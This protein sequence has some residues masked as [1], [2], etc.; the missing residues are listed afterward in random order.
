MLEPCC[1]NHV[2]TWPD[3]VRTPRSTFSVP[4]NRPLIHL[5]ASRQGQDDPI[6]QPTELAAII[7]ISIISKL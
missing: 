2:Y 6:L 3:L 7:T 5:T 1:S 4:P